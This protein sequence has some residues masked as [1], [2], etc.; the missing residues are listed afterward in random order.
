MTATFLKKDINRKTTKRFIVNIL[1]KGKNTN[2]PSLNED[3][4]VV[5]DN[6]LAVIDG[7]TSRLPINFGNK[8]GGQFVANVIKESLEKT[9]PT[10]NGLQL[11]EYL[12]R[13]LNIKFDEAGVREIIGKNPE[14]RPAALFTSGR[15]YN[16][17]LI[18]TTV[19][20]IGCRINGEKLLLDHFKID[21]VVI[22]KRV[23]VMKQAKKQNPT[24]SDEELL[25]VGKKAIEEDLK[26]Q[27]K[28]YYNN[29]NSDFGHGIIDGKDVP[30]KF[31]KTFS[32]SL[33]SIKTLEMFSDGYFKIGE[34]P[35]ITSWEKAFEKVENEDPLKWIKY[36]A[37]KGSTSE[38]FTDDRTILIAHKI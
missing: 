17:Q 10:L 33:D 27:T 23:N 20:D 12:T 29:P 22:A 38:Q 28:T 31:I 13:Q 24:I 3:R 18:I 15:I 25:E 4:W 34:S 11:V 9:E 2:D 1:S 7:A 36:A 14:A 5:T 37:V 19:G 6:T 16:S 8:T 30:E 26:E 35:S 32:F 21:E